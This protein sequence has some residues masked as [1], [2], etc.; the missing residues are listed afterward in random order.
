VKLLALQCLFTCAV[1]RHELLSLLFRV[2]LNICECME[3][4]TSCSAGWL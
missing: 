2:L 3:L 1:I 4:F